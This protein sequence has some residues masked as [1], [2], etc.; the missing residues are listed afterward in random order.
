MARRCVKLVMTLLVRDEADIIAEN[1]SFHLAQGVDH[2][3]ATDNLS[4]DAT[5]GIL[6]DF[7]RSG[8]LHYIR[9]TEDDY[10]QHRWVTHM[11]RLAHSS[12]GADWVINND[13]DEFWYPENGDLKK[14]LAAVPAG[15]DALT[16]RRVN[17]APRAMPPE[18]G[19]ADVMVWRDCES[20]NAL[21]QKLPDKVCHR[22]FGDVVVG[23]G[24]HAV[25]RA[26]RVVVPHPAPIMIL[27]FP[28]RSYRQFANKISK[29]GAALERNRELGPAIVATWRHLYQVYR[30][31]GLPAYWQQCLLTDAMLEERVRDGSL[32]RDDR[33]ARFFAN[34]KVGAG[35]AC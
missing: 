22:A 4:E 6:R 13:A 31:G 11:A 5:T 21:G 32:V 26:G 14:V 1:I 27:H 15:C 24:N 28:M 19:F 34:R 2:I 17:F 12:Y 33:L 25:M 20:R 30:D 3:I 7:E 9:Q 10:A 8:V 35:E 18:A 16:A 29:G 23:P